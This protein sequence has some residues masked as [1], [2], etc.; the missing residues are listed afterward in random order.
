[1]NS[2]WVQIIAIVTV[3]ICLILSL[4]LAPASADLHS[5]LVYALYIAIGVPAAAFGLRLLRGENG[6]PKKD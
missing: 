3:G 6:S 2:M 4:I 1:M 5:K